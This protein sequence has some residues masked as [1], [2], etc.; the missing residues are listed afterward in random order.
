ML[1]DISSFLFLGII[2]YL[3]SSIPIAY[4]WVKIKNR[5]LDLTQIGTGN[6]GASNTK[7][8]SGMLSAVLIALIDATC[9]GFI[10]IYILSNISE[11]SWELFLYGLILVLGHNWSIFMNFKGGR[12]I[13]VSIGILLA[14]DPLRMTFLIIAIPVVVG[15]WIVYKDSA[16]WT[17]MT[18]ILLNVI[19]FSISAEIMEKAFTV[20]LAIL[21]IGKRILSNEYFFPKHLNKF[22]VFMCRII[23]DRDIRSKH[24]WINK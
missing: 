14:I 19:T 15:R 17:F 16:L 23:F 4:V 13:A 8:I 3:I 21:L 9:K 12:G 11:Y 7:N 18:I 22:E 6:L 2:L 24:L 20:G 10:P 5:E 1:E